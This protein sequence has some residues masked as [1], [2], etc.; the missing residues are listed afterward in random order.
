MQLFLDDQHIIF[1]PPS[2]PRSTRGALRSQAKWQSSVRTRWPRISGRSCLQSQCL[3]T[4]I[5]RM[6]IAVEWW[7]EVCLLDRSCDH[8][9]TSTGDR[10]IYITPDNSVARNDQTYENR[11]N[12]PLT[13]AGQP[14]RSSGPFGNFPLNRDFLFD[15]H[16]QL[17]RLLPDP[18]NRGTASSS[19]KM[20]FALIVRVMSDKDLKAT[21]DKDKEKNIVTITSATNKRLSTKPSVDHRPECSWGQMGSF[22]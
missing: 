6:L 4:P 22:R 11:C 21:V 12:D 9:K 2:R 1:C 19:A 8:T 16:G 17:V 7:A 10:I 18:E 15:T 3:G 20:C 5:E 13:M 14:H